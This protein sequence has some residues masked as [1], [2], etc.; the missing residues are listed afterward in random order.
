MTSIQAITWPSFRCGGHDCNDRDPSVGA[1]PDEDG[2]GHLLSACGGD[3]CD[4]IRAWV[5][6]GAPE[7]CDGRDSNCDGLDPRSEDRDGDGY[8]PITATCRADVPGAFPSTDCWDDASDIEPGR[9][10]LCDGLDND[11]DAATPDGAAPDNGCL[12]GH[13]CMDG[14]CRQ[15]VGLAAV[16]NRTCAVLVDGS[17]RCWGS[18]SGGRCAEP[19]TDGGCYRPFDARGWTDIVALDERLEFAVDSLGQ[20]WSEQRLVVASG[21]RATAVSIE[22]C[23]VRADTHTV[24]CVDGGD[25]AGPTDVVQLVDGCARTGSGAV[26][27]WGENSFGEI[28]DGTTTARPVPVRVIDDGVT[29]LA[30]TSDARCAVRDGE[31]LCWGAAGTDGGRLHTIDPSRRVLGL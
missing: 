23:V 18:I 24:W 9:P 1:P 30:A 31:L 14:V 19:D 21:P 16:A 13:P 20:I 12:A 27:C 4:D 7:L 25:L 28:G 8:A 29:D 6:T 15:T 17:S 10:E 5:Y 26:W 22:L 3:D 11:C 2:D